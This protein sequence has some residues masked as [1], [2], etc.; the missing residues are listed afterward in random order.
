M[1]EFKW[2]GKDANGD[3]VAG[4]M[5]ADSVEA[6]TLHLRRQKITPVSIRKRAAGHG[7]VLS[8]TRILSTKNYCL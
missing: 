7:A 4:I 2:K 5:T 3:D 8:V 1:A 6:V